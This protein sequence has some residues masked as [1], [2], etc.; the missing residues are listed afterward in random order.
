MEF[1]TILLDIDGTILDFDAYEYIAFKSACELHEVPFSEI[2]YERY[3]VVN[4]SMWKKLE[5]GQITKEKLI[6]ERFR[7]LFDEIQIEKDV[8]AF[9]E[10]YQRILAEGCHFMDGAL[11]ILEYLAPKYDLYIVTNGVTETQIRKIEQ[12]GLD[13]YVKGVFISG[14]IGYHKPAKEYF[15]NCFAQIGDVDLN[16]TLIIG[17]SL[18]SD[19]RGGNHA[20]IRTCWYNPKHE[21]RGTEVTIN[22]E[23]HH[24][25]ELKNLL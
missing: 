11:E 24:L 14:Q 4:K 1:K 20:G 19:M 13:R 21:K 17:D 10:D 12:A 25:K 6:Y 9:E 2:L 15:D 7:Q 22:Y 5:F 18:S 16:K 3:H 23:I 8:Y